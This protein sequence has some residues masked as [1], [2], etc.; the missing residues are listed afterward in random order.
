MLKA[1]KNEQKED[2]GEL[3]KLDQKETSNDRLINVWPEQEHKA[4]HSG[5]QA[6][7]LNAF[8]S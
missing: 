3:P 8:I 7:Y 4:L 5:N 2:T 1:M 6:R